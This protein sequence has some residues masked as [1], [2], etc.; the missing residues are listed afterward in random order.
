[1]KVE[2]TKLPSRYKY[3]RL[4]SSGSFGEVYQVED[5]SNSKEIA[6]KI[7]KSIDGTAK[8]HMI[9]EFSTLSSLSH[10]NLVKVFDFG[11]TSDGNPFFTMELIKG[12]T[13]RNYLKDKR[14]V[15]NLS[16]IIHQALLALEYLHSNKILH[17][18]IKP[19][20]IMISKGAKLKLLDF[21][22][23]TKI[24]IKKKQISGT[25]GYLA[26]EV[27]KGT[28]YSESSDLYALG[29][30]IIESITGEKF[31]KYDNLKNI[32]M[33]SG[34]SNYSSLANFIIT[35]ASDDV[36]ERF[37]DSTQAL[38]ALE[39]GFSMLLK[40]SNKINLSNIFIGR[41]KELKL[42]KN[43]LDRKS[44]KNLLFL[45]GPKGIGKSSLINEAIKIAQVKGYIVISIDESSVKDSPIESLFS[46]I[47][48]SL[49]KRTANKIKKEYNTILSL[50]KQESFIETRIDQS[51]LINLYI[52]LTELIIN[53]SLKHRII[54]ILYL[55]LT[56]I[57]VL[58]A[59]EAAGNGILMTKGKKG[60]KGPFV[61]FFHTQRPSVR[62]ADPP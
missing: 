30:S 23:M 24:G 7:Y 62:K 27:L 48:N 16:K 17:G 56:Q 19:E 44:E 55:L 13:L 41:K 32:L 3:K 11:F 59:S 33:L 58:S 45:E 40:S 8:K 21:G 43:F 54:I 5:K 61:C 49:N 9:K 15:R 37:K 50:Y 18:D 51:Y 31:A 38:L 57:I 60:S 52:N 14:N 12:K 53:V 28:N 26:P 29:I 20:N 10:P 1:M 36:S 34:I 25:P 47:A 2:D 4:I 42:L 22:L 39:S 46:S 6:L 35:L